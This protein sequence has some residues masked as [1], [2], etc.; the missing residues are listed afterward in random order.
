MKVIMPIFAHADDQT[1]MASGYLARMSLKGS[2]IVPIIMTSSDYTDYNQD[3]QRTAIEVHQELINELQ[4]LGINYHN[5]YQL[6]IPT[7]QVQFNSVTIE[8]L[9]K[10]IDLE[11]PNLIITHHLEEQHQDHLNT[12]K[13]VLSAARRQNNIW[14]AEPMYPSKLSNGTFRPIIYV[15]ISTT[16]GIKIKAL[17]AHIS[18]WN[19]YP[20]WEDM[21]TSIA[22]LRGIEANTKF[23]E[24]FEPIKMVV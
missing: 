15:D 20:Y 8:T 10:I 5:C 2:I 3:I 18:Q 16:F 24:C 14:M 9:N 22:R 21:V 1:L 11:G 13:C 7:K 12:V 6:K 4:I 17:K 23:C 19:K